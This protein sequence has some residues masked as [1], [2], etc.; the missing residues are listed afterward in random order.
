L[1]I[2]DKLLPGMRC[3]LLTADGVEID[4]FNQPGELVVQSHSVVLGYLKNE[5]ATKETF[6]PDL[7]GHGRWMK[8]GDEAEFRVAPSGNVHL[9]ITDRIK[10][11]IKVQ[12][13]LEG[14]PRESNHI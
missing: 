9:A 3:K 2:D 7:D 6:L 13:S 11:L 5:K 14:P 8:T 12:V 4:G 10:E 1:L